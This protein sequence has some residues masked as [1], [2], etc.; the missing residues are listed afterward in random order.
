L[1]ENAFVYCCF[2][3]PYKILPGIFDIW[4]RLLRNNEHSVLWL[5]EWHHTAS[6]NLRSE[7]EKR[8]VSAE[9]VIFA[10]QMPLPDHLARYQHVDIFLDTLPYNAHTTARTHFGQ[11]SPC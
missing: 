8:G 7:A 9:R 6:A 10:R 11:A 1:P 5:F 4:M 2:N 3:N